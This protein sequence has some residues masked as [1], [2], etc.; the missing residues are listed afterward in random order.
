[1]R[2]IKIQKL[3]LCSKNKLTAA[4]L[5]VKD[6]NRK[7]MYSGAYSLYSNFDVILSAHLC[8]KLFIIIH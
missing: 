2:S 6:Q 5:C 4:F 7:L 1:M 8:K 3:I